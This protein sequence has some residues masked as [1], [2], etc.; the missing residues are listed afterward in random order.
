[1]SKRKNRN[2]PRMPRPP[3]VINPE[4]FAAEL[5]KPGLTILQF[6][7]DDHCA[8]WRGKDCDCD[9]HLKLLRLARE[10]E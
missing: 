5:T 9:P 2:Q 4:Q 3:K 8:H 1:M 6:R 7:H 10:D